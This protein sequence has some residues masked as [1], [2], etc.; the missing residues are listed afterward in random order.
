MFSDNAVWKYARSSWYQSGSQFYST[1]LFNTH[2]RFIEESPNQHTIIVGDYAYNNPLSTVLDPAGSELYAMS[3]GGP[4][5]PNVECFTITSGDFLNALGNILGWPPNN[6][7]FAIRYPDG[8]WFYGH[9]WHYYWPGVYTGLD[10]IYYGYIKGVES[11]KNG[12]FLW[13]LEDAPEFYATRWKLS[14]SGFPYSQT[15]DNAYFGTGAQTDA[16]NG[17]YSGR[18]ITRDDQNRYFILD[19]LSTGQPRTKMW[20]VNGNVTTSK[21]GFGD[22]TSIS[23]TPLRIEGSE[24]SGDVVVLHGDTPPYMISVFVPFE[25]P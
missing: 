11:D 22:S 13:Y 1:A 23:A 2:L 25:M 3:Q 4:D 9:Q 10:Q 24:F 18:D 5:Y 8:D 15:Y 17:F 16:D 7:T 21:G 6:A 20:T 14:T 19:R 12:N